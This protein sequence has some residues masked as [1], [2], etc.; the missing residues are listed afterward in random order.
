LEDREWRGDASTP[1]SKSLANEDDAFV[2]NGKLELESSMED[3]NE[4]ELEGRLLKLR[5]WPFLLPHLILMLFFLCRRLSVDGAVW[6]LGSGRKAGGRA[7]IDFGSN[8]LR[9][10]ASRSLATCGETSWLSSELLELATERRLGIIGIESLKLV[11]LEKLAKDVRD[12]TLLS[13]AMSF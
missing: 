1:S 10:L 3:E 5:L 8:D 12:V 2:G 11:R 9:I 7:C 6:D 13:S 4:H